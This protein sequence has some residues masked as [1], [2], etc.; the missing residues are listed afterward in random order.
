MLFL[1]IHSNTF[2]SALLSILK[3]K[4]IADLSL[5]TKS[6]KE[7]EQQVKASKLLGTAGHCSTCGVF[8]T[9]FD[10]VQIYGA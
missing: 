8:P 3:K 4:I 2:S 9:V 1:L 7:R 5:P 10:S 6:H